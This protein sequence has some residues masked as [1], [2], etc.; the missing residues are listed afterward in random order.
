MHVCEALIYTNLSSANVR[1][2]T[3][4][5]TLILR[6]GGQG[7]VNSF[8]SGISD[9]SLN[10]LAFKCSPELPRKWLNGYLPAKKYTLWIPR[11]SNFSQDLPHEC[12]HGSVTTINIH[13]ES[14]YLP[15]IFQSWCGKEDFVWKTGGGRRQR[16][17]QWFMVQQ[18]W[19]A[20]LVD[21]S[22]SDYW[23]F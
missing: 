4:W 11:P 3:L 17:M 6:R 14:L 7:V 22:S 1:K 18:P 21:H 23:I 8:S 10:P 5:V 12:L 2:V 20:L 16:F 13:F 9:H 19:G 15:I